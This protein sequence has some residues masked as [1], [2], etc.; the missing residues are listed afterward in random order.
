MPVLEDELRRYGDLLDTAADAPEPGHTFALTTDERPRRVAR[1]VLA[2]AA[3]VVIVVLVAVLASA[4]STHEVAPATTPSTDAVTSTTVQTTTTPT[5][6]TSRAAADAAAHEATLAARAEGVRWI[7]TYGG[8]R[9]PLPDASGPLAVTPHAFLAISTGAWADS[10]TTLFRIDRVTHRVTSLPLGPHS[11]GNSVAA[12]TVG[13]GALYAQT[14]FG[15]NWQLRR[16]DPDTL[17]VLWT[18]S[19]GGSDAVS[20]DHAVAGGS[21]WVW[22]SANGHLEQRDARTGRVLRTISR[23]LRD[24]YDATI[25]LSPDLHTLYV[26]YGDF[27]RGGSEPIETRDAATGARLAYRAQSVTSVG[28]PTLYP[29]AAGVWVAFRN[30]TTGGAWFLRAKDLLSTTGVLVIDGKNSFEQGVD[31]AFSGSTLWAR[32]PNFGI[33]CA[34]ARWGT[35]I[36]TPDPAPAT[37]TIAADEST[38][39]VTVNGAVGIFVPDDLCPAVE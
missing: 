10:P 5:T 31:L 36:G 3:V 21:D 19:L 13:G 37:T 20:T 22:V 39:V 11:S 12:L 34:N 9:V 29:T 26:A 24:N 14:N 4:R 32:N 6:V 16:I 28:P 15:E 33:A 1:T 7:E 25:A 35:Q 27:V 38:V 2:A 23:P 17:R 8:T 18:V 30:G